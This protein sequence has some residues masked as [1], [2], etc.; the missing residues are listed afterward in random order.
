MR[1]KQNFWDE[2]QFID[3][4]WL[5]LVLGVF[6]VIGLNLKCAV[7]N[8]C[9]EESKDFYA[10]LMSVPEG[11]TVLIQS[12][13]TTST[14]G[15]S[16][17]HLESLLRILMVKRVK[18]L[19]YTFADPQAPQVWR[20]VIRVINEERESQNLPVYRPWVDYIDV[21]YFANAEGSSIAVR[22]DI[23][24]FF[25]RQVKDDKGINRSIFESPVMTKINKVGDADLF[26]IVT[27]S[28]SL[29]VAVQRLSDRVKM[30]A[31]VTGV[32]GPTALTF[33]QSGQLKGVAIGLKGVYDTEYMME[34]G[35]NLPGPDGKIAVEYSKSDAPVPK[36]TEGKTLARGS[37]YIVALHFALGLV[38]FAVVVG[39]IAMF[40]S[41]AATKGGKRR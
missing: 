31:M 11:G 3:R 23:R 38:I 17:G 5:Y 35:L 30:A 14:R 13:W 41:R 29:D 40:A 28:A 2:I 37:S 39:N 24:R 1:R 15:E 18:F 32:I 25:S 16:Q 26:V 12:D 34:N 20:N 21:G 10:T 19:I 33:Y 8:V 22:N 36:I 7:S 4:R 6:L 9:A 27:A